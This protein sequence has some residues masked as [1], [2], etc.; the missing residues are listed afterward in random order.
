MTTG[1]I[2]KFFAVSFFVVA[3]G[4]CQVTE[5]QL[6]AYIN[7]RGFK[8]IV[9]PS[10]LYVPGSLVN[11][12]NYDPKDT[13]PKSVQLGFLCSPSYSVERYGKKPIASET[14][15]EYTVT[16]L[17][18]GFSA[19]VPALKRI[20]DL[21]A[22]AKGK[23]TLT[24]S[25]SNARIYAFAQDD[26]EF[27]RGMLGP[28]CRNIVNRNV[29]HNA[30]QV[31]QVLEASISV[32][33]QFEDGIDASAKAKL[34]KELANA[35]F[36]ISANNSATLSGQALFFGV[37]LIPITEPIRDNSDPALVATNRN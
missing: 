19:T 30:F 25:V 34:V 3:L 7:S 8:L 36:S 9:P 27:V 20:I 16:Q 23:M 32:T 11:L 28:Q 37:Q 22:S 35:N 26:L 24:G 10:T 17:G 21:S 18:G 15:G 5:D 14:L 13:N 4:G 1:S 33:A 31:A 6:Q 12:Q 29:P 2:C